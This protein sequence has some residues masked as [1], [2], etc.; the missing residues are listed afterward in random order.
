MR[1]YLSTLP[2]RQ[3]LRCNTSLSCLE[4]QYLQESLAM[5]QA[6]STRLKLQCF[7]RLC[8]IVLLD[9]NMATLQAVSIR[10]KLQGVQRGWFNVLLDVSLATLQVVSTRL[11]LEGVQRLCFNIL[12]DVSNLSKTTSCDG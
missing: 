1:T 9:V 12:L 2:Y 10:L 6:V 7:Q 4:N 5:L 11:K 3:T 8:F